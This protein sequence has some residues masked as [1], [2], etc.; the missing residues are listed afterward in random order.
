ME[1]YEVGPLIGKGAYGN[2]KSA[3]EL[4]TG[5][6]VAIKTIGK[7]FDNV[8]DTIRTLREMEILK[9][10]KNCNLIIQASDVIVPTSI[11]NF[12]HIDI[13]FE[14]MDMDLHKAIKYIEPVH[15]DHIL[16]QMLQGINYVHACGILHRDIKPGNIFVNIK[17]CKVKIG[18][19][20]LARFNV[21]PQSD[22]K[23]VWS[24]Y[25]STRW[26]RAPE[27]CGSFDNQ[28]TYAID[29]WSIG[30]VYAEML[31]KRPLFPG[32]NT[33]D[34]LICIMM[35]IG[36][37]PDNVIAKI[38]NKITR[39]FFMNAPNYKCKLDEMFADIAP[40]KLDLLKK[41]LTFDPDERI[42]AYDAI[43]H[44]MFRKLKKEK[45]EIPEGIQKVMEDLEY[46]EN[47]L[48]TSILRGAIYDSAKTFK[49]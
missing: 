32:C 4:S 33:V 49:Q 18:D 8:N 27:I 25:V 35:I 14:I 36:K 31:K 6:K 2:V 3:V 48:E 23:N 37:P 24:G 43:R 28:Y 42:T 10:L 22:E 26:Y 34:Q 21:S 41:L 11:D 38:K 40:E 13:V 17:D 12:H 46:F 16:F 29:I 15:C 44:S 7:L 39:K 30:C 47:N 1:D 45:Y 9:S 5:I 19:F 20:G